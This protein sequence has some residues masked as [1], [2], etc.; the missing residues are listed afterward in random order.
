M[1]TYQSE[2]DEVVILERFTEGTTITSKKVMN[3]EKILAIQSFT[4][5]QYTPA[6]IK[7]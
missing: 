5:R 4:R 1:M 2:E 7:C 6:A 3:T